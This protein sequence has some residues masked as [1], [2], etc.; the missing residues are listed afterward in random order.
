MVVTSSDGTQVNTYELT[1]HRSY[2]VLV[3]YY[4]NKNNLLDAITVY[5]GDEFVASYAPD[6]A[7][8]TF[9]GWKDGDGA[10]CGCGD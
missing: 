10:P 6:I 3:N 7:G 4:D 9:N 2:A 5:T 1:I 8:Y